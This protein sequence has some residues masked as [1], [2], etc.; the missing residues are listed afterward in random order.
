MF[1]GRNNDVKVKFTPSDFITDN[2][3]ELKV[4]DEILKFE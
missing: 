3:D 1:Q 2:P 4:L